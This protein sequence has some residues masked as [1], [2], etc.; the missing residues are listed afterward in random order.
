MYYR[1]KAFFWNIFC[2]LR[3][4]LL[5]NADLLLLTA[6]WSS[7]GCECWQE[8]GVGRVLRLFPNEGRRLGDKW[9]KMRGQAKCF[10]K[11]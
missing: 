3:L 6:L 5:S 8:D 9:A 7:L 11:I 10:S 4:L 2:K 1:R